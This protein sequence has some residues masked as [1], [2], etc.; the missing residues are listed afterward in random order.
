MSKMM[1]NEMMIEW[2]LDEMMVEDIDCGCD[3]CSLIRAG[4]GRKACAEVGFWEYGCSK[5]VVGLR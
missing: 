4:R 1:M 5:G 3:V 2:G